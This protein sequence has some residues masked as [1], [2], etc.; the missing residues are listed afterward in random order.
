MPSMT[1]AGDAKRVMEHR[2]EVDGRDLFGVCTSC[3]EKRHLTDSNQMYYPRTDLCVTRFKVGNLSNVV[4]GKLLDAVQRLKKCQDNH[5]V[6]QL[7]MSIQIFRVTLSVSSFFLLKFFGDRGP[8][9]STIYLS[10]CERVSPPL[11]SSVPN[12]P[13]HDRQC[14]RKISSSQTFAGIVRNILAKR[15]TA[16]RNS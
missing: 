10:R 14:S 9:P 4:A 6:F 8:R 7:E 1:S 15:G 3:N 5:S 2:I 11:S 16:N 13:L 12:Y